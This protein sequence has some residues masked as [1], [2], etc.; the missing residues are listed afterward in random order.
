M[1]TLFKQPMLMKPLYAALLLVPLDAY[2]ADPQTTPNAGSILQ[3]LQPA[4][5]AAAKPNAPTL[6]VKPKSDAGLPPS[7]PIQVTALRITGHTAFS[8]ETLHALLADQ[9]GKSLTL[10]QL[11]EVAGRITAYYQ[12]RGFP[13]SRAIIPVQSITGGVILIQVV[14]AHYGKVRL[15]NRSEVGDALLQASLA[16]L[17]GGQLIADADLDRALLL[18]SDV[19][20]VGVNAVLK[21]GSAVGTADMDVEARYVRVPLANISLD[22]YGSRYIGR[23]RLSGNFNIVN[24]FHHGDILSANLVS[25]GEGMNYGRLGYDT[26]LNGQGTR[27]GGAYSALHYKLGSTARALDANG[28]ARVASL[29]AKQPLIRSKQFNVYAQLQYDAKNL[30]DH[31]DVSGLRTDRHLHNWIASVN[32]DLRDGL[33]GGG[34]SIASLGWTS[35]RGGFDNGSAAAADAATA[36]TGGGFS[37]WNAN[38]ARLQWLTPRDSLY[39]NFSG[40][41]AD[42]NLDSAEK[43][44]AGGPYTVRA[45]DSGALSGDTGY[46]GTVEM[47]HDL[48]AMPFGKWQVLAFADSAHVKVNRHPWTRA[49]NS[50]TLSGAGVG[51]NWAGPGQWRASVSVATRLGA[52]PSMLARPSSV[53]AWLVAGKGF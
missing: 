52:V 34:M 29:W 25:T 47:R 31:I 6:E 5:P 26:L 48:G 11:D 36:R 41:W 20:G 35:G 44:T 39:L 38:I 27:I 53:R 15:N 3:Q 4:L 13:L 19:P 28:T 46:V 24:P 33:L 43:M 45:Y 2:A 1:T 10:P 12:E 8:T 40:Q 7:P 21:P 9:E 22:N 32:G 17:S 42:G 50:A 51:L 30:R 16:P 14:E 49:E 23:T 37:K 18:L